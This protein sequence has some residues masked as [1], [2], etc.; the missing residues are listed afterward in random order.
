MAQGFIFRHSDNHQDPTRH[1][2]YPFKQTEVGYANGAVKLVNGEWTKAGATDAVGGIL[3]NNVKAGETECEVLEVRPGDVFEVTY[4]GTP[5]AGFTPGANAVALGTNGVAVDSA[6]TT[7]G[8]VV[9]MDV[10]TNKKIAQVQFKN[11]QFS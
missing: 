4:T 2:K 11:R 7:G 10:N 3:Q 1:T 9:V 6:T 5:G 8:P